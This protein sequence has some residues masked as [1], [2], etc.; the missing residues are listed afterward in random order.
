M[1]PRLHSGMQQLGRYSESTSVLIR[2]A[3]NFSMDRTNARLYFDDLAPLIDLA[4]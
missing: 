1:I 2:E 4:L 3:L